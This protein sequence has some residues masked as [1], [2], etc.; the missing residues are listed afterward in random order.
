MQFVSVE[1]VADLL[2][3]PLEDA[4]ALGD[5]LGVADSEWDEDAILE[6]R[7]LLEDDAEDPD[8]DSGDE[9]EDGDDEDGDSDDEDDED[10]DLDEEE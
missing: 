1:F 7:E 4:Q 3:I 6:A 8:S 2:Q 9:D 10:A 5:E